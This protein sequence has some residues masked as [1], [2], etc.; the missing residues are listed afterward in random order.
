MDF[1]CGLVERRM[2]REKSWSLV[3]QNRIGLT[4]ACGPFIFFYCCFFFFLG[5]FGGEPNW[6]EC[7]SGSSGRLVSVH[8]CT[9]IYIYMHVHM[10]AYCVCKSG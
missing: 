10:Y 3:K 2:K 9:Y 7:G 5:F 1:L 6:M 8:L 4:I